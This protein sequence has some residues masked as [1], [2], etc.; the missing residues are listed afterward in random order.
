MTR[1]WAY[2]SRDW[3]VEEARN[4]QASNDDKPFGP[5]ICAVR[6]TP[7]VIRNVWLVFKRGRRYAG[8]RERRKAFTK[9]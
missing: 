8:G 4:N 2:S 7:R 5:M 9:Y 3:A 1:D 6:A